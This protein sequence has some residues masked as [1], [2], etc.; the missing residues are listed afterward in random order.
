MS[1]VRPIQLSTDVLIIGGGLAGCWAAL[2]A[3]D[4][5]C[6]VILVDKGYIGLAGASPMSG[7]VTTCPLRNDDLQEWARDFIELG[8]YMANQ[9]WLKD[10]LDDLVERIEDL[11]AMGIPILREPDGSILRKQSRGALNVKVLQWFPRTGMKLFRQILEQRPNVTLSDRIMVTK[12][13]T[14]DGAF[15]SRPG[16]CG[17]VGFHTRSGDY[18]TYSAKSVVL[19]GGPINMKG[20]HP[21]DNVGTDGPMMAFRAGADLVDL[22]FSF[23]GTFQHLLNLYKLPSFNIALAH[24]GKLLNGRGERFMQKH[25]PVR[26]ERSELPR[27]LAA[28][29]REIAEDRGP[30]FLDFRDCDETYYQNMT[31]ISG[32][33]MASL[34]SSPSLPDPK[35]YPIPIE[36]YY[37]IWSHQS[38][39]RILDLSCQTT[40]RNLYAAGA[41]ARNEA[42]GT[43]SSAGMPSAW[44]H[45]SGYRAGIAAAQNALKQS[46]I[47]LDFTNEVELSHEIFAPLFTP[48]DSN[49]DVIIRRLTAIVG[50]PVENMILDEESAQKKVTLL[51]ELKSELRN[52]KVRARH[53]HD[54]VKY[55]EVVNNI[56]M[57]RL[58]YLAVIERKES[59]DPLF[60][61]DFPETNNK[62]WFCWLDVKHQGEDTIEFQKRPIPLHEYPIQPQMPLGKTKSHLATILV[63]GGGYHKYSKH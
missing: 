57:A 9:F 54:L 52:Q 14:Q 19:T 30:I 8:H 34:F 38:G 32:P 26:L 33:K 47:Q 24:G 35:K 25:D 12:L 36:P 1:F 5:G 39:V 23:G 42:I 17:A 45:V 3:S 58:I 21:I 50:N 31:Q 29:I 62:E 18:Y 4:M 43:H 20:F 60:R 46:E 41:M 37:T 28:A 10:I 2:K 44:A 15:S 7:G 11:Q 61:I 27:V 63:E 51:S 6:D 59:R 16:V 49:P 40:L 55:H 53:Y 13:I 48:G 56:E 22:E